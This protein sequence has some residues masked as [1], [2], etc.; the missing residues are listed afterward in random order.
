MRAE[1][2]RHF[3]LVFVDIISETAAQ[4]TMPDLKYI[5]EARSMYQVYHYRHFEE[6]FEN[7]DPADPCSTAQYRSSNFLIAVVNKDGTQHTNAITFVHKGKRD[8]LPFQIAPNLH[9]FSVGHT[10]VLMAQLSLRH[11]HSITWVQA[12][13]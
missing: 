2:F 1:Q 4:A 7:P 12:I 9:G 13:R 10:H 3:F 5:E 11:V 8:E 6:V